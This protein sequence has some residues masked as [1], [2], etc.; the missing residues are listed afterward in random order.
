ML[1]DQLPS[2][3][4]TSLRMPGVDNLIF[5]VKASVLKETDEVPK[6]GFVGD[7]SLLVNSGEGELLLFFTHTECL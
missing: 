2:Y 4:T 5:M 3:T 1:I 7:C 6:F